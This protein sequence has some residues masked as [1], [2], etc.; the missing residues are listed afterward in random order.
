V[1]SSVDDAIS[2]IEKNIVRY[3]RQGDDTVHE[4]ALGGT[5]RIGL[6]V[7]SRSTFSMI[8]VFIQRI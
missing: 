2:L 3:A 7:S 6:K 8:A 1:V 4:A 5:A